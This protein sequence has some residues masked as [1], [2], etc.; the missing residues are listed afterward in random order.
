MTNGNNTQT[1]TQVLDF[2]K[3]FNALLLSIVSFGLIVFFNDVKD[4]QSKQQEIWVKVSQ[5]N[6]IEENTLRRLDKF[7]NKL[8]KI[9]HDVEQ[10]KGKLNK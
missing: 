1:K 7:E 5:F 4:I 3:W 10:I 6:I 8:E 2:L 9:E